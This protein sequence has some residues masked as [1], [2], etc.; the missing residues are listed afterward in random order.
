MKY[1]WH[2][3]GHQEDIDGKNAAEWFYEYG[4]VINPD[5]FLAIVMDKGSSDLTYLDLNADGHAIT[6]ISLLSF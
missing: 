6:S 1:V 2:F 3:S 5:K 4:M